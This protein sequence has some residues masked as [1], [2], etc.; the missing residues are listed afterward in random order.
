MPVHSDSAAENC[1]ARDR[2]N[3]GIAVF[4]LVHILPE[5]IAEKKRHPQT[6]AIQCLC[7]H[8]TFSVQLRLR[9]RRPSR[10]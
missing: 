7:N 5:K 1:R 10:Y 6:H 2:A 8:S 3:I 9:A 4:W